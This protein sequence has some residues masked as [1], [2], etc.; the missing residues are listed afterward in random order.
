MCAV[1][2]KVHYFTAVFV[3]YVVWH[4]NTQRQLTHSGSFYFR[5]LSCAFREISLKPCARLPN[6]LPPTCD[7]SQMKKRAVLD[8]L[9]GMRKQGLCHA[10]FAAPSEAS[11]MLQVMALAQPF[12]A[13]G[14]AGMESAW[15][16]AADRGKNRGVAGDVQDKGGKYYLRSVSELSR[17]RLESGAPVSR[18]VTRREAEVSRRL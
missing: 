8:L 16:F 2:Y 18:D 10:K 12:S 17:L 13:D 6:L 7:A 15:L 3:A 1:T 5:G 9:G 11:D 4:R 14:L